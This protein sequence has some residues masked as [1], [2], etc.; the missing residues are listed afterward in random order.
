MNWINI[1]VFMLVLIPVTILSGKIF[2][3]GKA[4]T[5]NLTKKSLIPLILVIPYLLFMEKF[6][7][8]F[9][10]FF[11]AGFVAYFTILGIVRVIRGL[12]SP[13]RYL[14]YVGVFIPILFLKFIDNS[15]VIPVV[16]INQIM[17]VFFAI[18]MFRNPSMNGYWIEAKLEEITEGLKKGCPYGKKPVI[19]ERG[20]EF[21]FITGIR[22]LRIW[23]KKNRSIVK[24]SKKMH[25]K[26]GSPDLLSFSEKLVE[27]II[28][29]TNLKK[30][31]NRI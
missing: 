18:Y 6:P 24:I 5:I 11:L 31:K 4:K 17:F 1:L 30:S 15:W 3:R 21:P 26:I 8:W 27:E 16:A 28:L 29:N 7:Q 14:L 13:K 10:W 23:V 2:S 22:G 20:N 9:S 25:E 19:V 12:E